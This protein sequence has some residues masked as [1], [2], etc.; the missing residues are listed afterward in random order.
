MFVLLALVPVPVI[1]LL[2]YAN[3]PQTAFTLQRRSA[4]PACSEVRLQWTRLQQLPEYV[5][6]SA[7]A[8][9]DQTFYEHAGFDVGAIRDALR[10]RADGG[11]MRG[12]STLSQ[13]VTKNLFLWSDKS[14]MRK[15]LEAY[16]TLWLELIL[17]KPRI[18][19]IYLNVAQF[20]AC[21]FGIEPASQHYFGITASELTPDQAAR[22]M[23]LLPS[24]SSRHPIELTPLQAERTEQIRTQAGMLARRARRRAGTRD[25]ARRD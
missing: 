5:G 3:P 10:E 21:V 13:Q 8:A 6:W 2:R 9:E 14:W 20:D 25:S 15:G 1:F 7:I 16:L 12:A 22:L 17:P 11:R 4:S 18:L 19:E 24:P 23:T